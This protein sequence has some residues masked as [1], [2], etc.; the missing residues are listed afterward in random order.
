MTVNVSEYLRAAAARD[1]DGTALI[2]HRPDRHAITWR[3]LD[4]AADA[5]AQ[6]LS[7][8][9]LVAGQRVAIVMANRVDLPIA[10]YGILRGGMV[11]VPINPRS[12]T[13][14]IGRMLA[15]SRARVVLCDEA[16]VAQVR[17]AVTND[18]AVAIVVKGTEP[19]GEETAFERF[20][21]DATGAAPAA[22]ADAEALAVILYTSG[23]S[24]KP[25]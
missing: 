11:A 25:R 20:L 15:D 5:V 6:A 7:G 2:E 4:A 23:T 19:I 12:T 3:E 24:G 21:A 22:P 14:E 16:G 13:R 18:F 9:G 1:P 8:R 10:Y 17:E